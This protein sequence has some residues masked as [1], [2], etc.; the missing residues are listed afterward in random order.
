MLI[1]KQI[2]EETFDGWRVELEQVDDN[3]VIGINISE[4]Q[5]YS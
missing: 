1:Q 4:S 5:F 2:L 3:L